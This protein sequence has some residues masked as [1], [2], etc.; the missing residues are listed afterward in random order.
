MSVKIRCHRCNHEN[1]PGARVCVQC[2]ARISESARANAKLGLRA[3]TASIPLGKFVPVLVLTIFL[4]LFAF[5]SPSAEMD[6]AVL[7][8]FGLLGLVALGVTFPLTK[9]HYDFSCGPVAG[10]VACLTI[11]ATQ[12][13]EPLLMLPIPLT[14]TVVGV[15]VGL[16]VGLLN[17]LVIGWTRIP[18]AV[19][20]IIVALGATELAHT[21]SRGRDLTVGSPS[22]QALGEASFAGI[23][24]P[25]MLLLAAALVAVLLW[26]RETF[27]P[28]SRVSTRKWV[29]RLTAPN[30]ILWSFAVSGIMAGLAGVFI[31]ACGLPVTSPLGHS[32]WI[33]AP[34]TAAILG[35]GVVAAGIGGVGTAL[36]GAAALSVVGYVLTVMRVPIAGPVS[37]GLLLGFCLLSS[38]VLGC[39]WYEFQ[40]LRRG[41]LLGIPGAQRVP[42]LLFH[43]RYSR[44]IWVSTAA[45]VGVLAYGY[46]AVYRVLYVPEDQVAVVMIDGDVR[47]WEKRVEGLDPLEK[48]ATMHALLGKDDRVATGA[49]SECMLRLSDGSHV[50]LGPDSDM[51]V[52]QVL[53]EADGTRDVRM[54]VSS[55]SVWADVEPAATAESQFEVST[56]LLTVAVRGTQ[57]HI[58]VGR[59][60]TS[61][62]VLEGTVSLLRFFS[63][64]DKYGQSQ[65]RREH[66]RLLGGE[67]LM[68]QIDL[69]MGRPYP[70]PEM[71]VHRMRLLGEQAGNEVF[72]ALFG[73]RF[74]KALAGIGVLIVGIYLLFAFG[75]AGPARAILPEDVEEAVRRLEATRTRTADDSPRAVAIA[76]MHLQLGNV[77]EARAELRRIV[78]TDATSRYGQWA[79]RMLAQLEPGRP[80]ESTDGGDVDGDDAES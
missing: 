38:Q 14:A 46:V 5:L 23:P 54:D 48:V 56:P 31:A 12:R 49:G 22:F 3:R 33:L 57:F 10:L 7:I 16:L 59:Q 45:V 42:D 72:R 39:T 63:A 21:I 40:E 1:D 19:F 70:L 60:K 8:Q 20:T 55:G 51:R 2:Y 80:D 64:R 30:S 18:S 9:G 77:D 4:A 61:V 53:Q 36:L 47:I 37:E 76:Q 65:T 6:R 41:N 15:V 11:I 67:G 24:A 62:G 25:L 79:E 27:W 52:L 50:H 74:I 13:Q 29:L 75:A 69:P 58:E 66:G 34:I 78:E 28:L 73:W 35:G 71:E 17:G 68:V 26:R 44:L 43:S 32:T